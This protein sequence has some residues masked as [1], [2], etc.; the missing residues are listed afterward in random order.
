[1][2]NSPVSADFEEASPRCFVSLCYKTAARIVHGKRAETLPPLPRKL[3]PISADEVPTIGKETR[4]VS[5][6]ETPRLF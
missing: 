5:L 2:C 4:E 1:M 3:F 6:N